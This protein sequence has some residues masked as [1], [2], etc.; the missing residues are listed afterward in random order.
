ME[1][2]VDLDISLRSLE[3]L[4]ERRGGTSLCGA[5]RND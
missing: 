5:D 4:P 2:T 3:V 1:G